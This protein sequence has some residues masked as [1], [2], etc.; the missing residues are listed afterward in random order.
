MAMSSFAEVVKSCAR[1]EI[2]VCGDGR[3]VEQS[4]TRASE[5]GGKL[6][7]GYHSLGD[8]ANNNDGKISF[9]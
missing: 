8:I 6:R 5:T 1:V 2:A 3:R 9:Q 7:Q 4:V